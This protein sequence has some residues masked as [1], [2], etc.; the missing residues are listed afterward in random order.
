MNLV[1]PG[2]IYVKYIWGIPSC[3]IS[4]IILINTVVAAV[5]LL[6]SINK[7]LQSL[8]HMKPMHAFQNSQ[9]WTFASTELH[10]CIVKP[11]S[12]MSALL[13]FSTGIHIKNVALQHIFVKAIQLGDPFFLWWLCFLL[14]LCNSSFSSLDYI[15]LNDRMVNE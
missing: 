13:L 2:L 5:I 8:L 4:C 11:V 12:L 14:G 7:F 6:C 1:N 10:I 3:L 15:A 9:N